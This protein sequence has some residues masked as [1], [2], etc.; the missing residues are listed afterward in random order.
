MSASLLLVVPQPY[1]P[2]LELYL[3]LEL[4]Q[5]ELLNSF[6]DKIPDTEVMK[7]QGCKA[8]KD[9]KGQLKMT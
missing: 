8:C 5:V 6:Q 1:R 7:R 3:H 2:R 4:Y 9:L